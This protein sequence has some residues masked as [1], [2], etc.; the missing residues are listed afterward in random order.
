MS[1]RVVDIIGRSAE[2]AAR[3][4]IRTPYTHLLPAK[5]NIFPR[6][7]DVE[8]ASRS[9]LF[10]V[11][12]VFATAFLVVSLKLIDASIYAPPHEI[13]LEPN[14][15]VASLPTKQQFRANIV[16][17][18]G[19][20]IASSLP[21]ASLCARPK[22]IRDPS[23]AAFLIAGVL[24]DTSAA[25]I[26]A[27]LERGREYVFL[28]RHITPSQHKAL[29]ALGLPGLCF[30]REQRRVYPQGPLAAHV[31][32]FTNIDGKGLG[33]VELEFDDVLRDRED[34][35][36]LSI[37]LRVQRIVREEVQFAIDK[38]SAIGGV[39]LMMD[40]ENG[41]FLA[42]VS[43]PDFDP[44]NA[45]AATEDSRRN[46]ATLGTYEMGS[47]FKLITA[48]QALQTGQ[49]ELNSMFDATKPI[50]VGRFRISDFHPQ[51]RWL[52][53][54]EVLIHSSNIGAAKMAELGGVDQQKAFLNRLGMLKP[55]SLELPEIGV[56]QVP[57]R[58][59]ETSMRTISY[60]YGISVTPVHVATAI[61]GLV[62]GGILHQPTILK[63]LN[64]ERPK[65]RKVITE[66]V[67]S[68]IRWLMRQVVVNGTGTQA[69]AKFYPVGGKTGSAEK[70]TAGG[71]GYD[72][73]SNLVSFVAAFP[74]QAP[75]YALLVMVDGPKPRKD[76][77]GYATG[78]WVAAPAAR[79]IIERAAPVLGITPI[80][81]EATDRPEPIL[82]I[83]KIKA[84]KS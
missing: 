38:F 31:A 70:R 58:W 5:I 53:L 16:D 33:G 73:N 26:Q 50:R 12:A 55:T 54:E 35:L 10:V 24:P 56:P 84:R 83:T 30:E 22:L 32:G 14:R 62:N 69:E 25:A 48:A 60:G 15:A 29:L 47:T 18:H 68:K 42:M 82:Q 46:Q 9:R 81:L 66:N 72:K 64:N 23:A 28:K 40:V 63:R 44:N 51:N 11:G 7:P 19:E 75:R 67:S 20:L 27:E 65:G 71:T 76:T 36:A 59:S 80:G 39:G 13:H 21:I 4:K 2:K 1:A 49:A 61:S 79:K 52:S 43:L 57:R 8:E 3:Y 77:F 41:E 78:G 17:R 45:A 6:R 37:D 34:P 74:I